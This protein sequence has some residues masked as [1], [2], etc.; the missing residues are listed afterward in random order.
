MILLKHA[1]ERE[2][3]LLEAVVR[4]ID[5][6]DQLGDERERVLALSF[7]LEG[8]EAAPERIQRVLAD[9]QVKES[10]MTAAEKLRTEGALQSSRGI[11]LRQLQ[12]KFPGQVSAAQ[13]GQ[14][15]G[16]TLPALDAWLDRVVDAATVDEVFADPE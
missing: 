1:R 4:G 15:A 10:V 3:A 6:L 11:L 9:A 2:E 13:E 14:I 12:R 5:L 7:I 16:A 8:T